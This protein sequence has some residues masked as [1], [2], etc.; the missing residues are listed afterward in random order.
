MLQGWQ[1]NSICL[2]HKIPL[3]L[4]HPGGLVQYYIIS[5][6]LDGRVA[7]KLARELSVAFMASFSEIH[8]C[9]FKLLGVVT[10]WLFR[11]NGVEIH[12]F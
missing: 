9:E 2:Q 11:E 1:K 8:G 4:R 3:Y 7:L 10:V 6:P 12:L 5:M